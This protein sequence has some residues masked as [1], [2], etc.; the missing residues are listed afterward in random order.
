M[1]KHPALAALAG[2]L[3]MS[4]AI[5][6]A[7]Q[8]GAA[9][10]E[11]RHYAGDRGSTKYSALDQIDR[12][13]FSELQVAWRWQSADAFLEESVELRP[14]HFRGTPLMVGGVVYQ[15]TGLSQVAA[16]DAGTGETLWVHD[17]R[18]YERGSVVHGLVQIRGIEYW[19]DGKEER[20]L[21]A[22]GGRQLV[23]LDSTTGKPDTA[24]GNGGFVDLTED[25]GRDV[26]NNIGHSAPVITIGDTIV[27][28]SLVFDFPTRNS[29]PP[30]HVRGYDVRSG[31]LKWRFHSIPQEG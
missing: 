2:L 6:S 26:N 17:P 8:T 1:R 18:S 24:F 3:A 11:W 4:I 13:N 30:G 5:P 12:D 29:N 21:I 20:I 7:A 25:L 9:K 27:V 16:L 28:G 23:S 19:T 31:E 14:G 10:G 22:T 15:P